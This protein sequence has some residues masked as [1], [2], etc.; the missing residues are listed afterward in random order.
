M[1][2][3]R[4]S[5]GF[6][7]GHLSG[8]LTGLTGLRTRLQFSQWFH[9][10]F[11]PALRPVLRL[12]PGFLGALLFAVMAVFARLCREEMTFGQLVFARASGAIVVLGV[13]FRRELKDVFTKGTGILW[14]RAFFG[15]V[16]VFCYYI[17]IYESSIGLATT[18]NNL[19]PVFVLLISAFSLK[20]KVSPFAVVGVALATVGVGV[21]SMPREGFLEIKVLATGI[22]GALAT[23]LAYLSLKKATGR[24]SSGV[25][26][27]CFSIVL[28]FF[29]L[30]D[31]TVYQVNWQTIPW[32][33]LM[34]M[35]LTALLA[36]LFMTISFRAQ[37]ATTGATVNLTVVVWAVLGDILI[38]GTHFPLSSALG[39]LAVLVGVFL[40]RSRES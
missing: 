9:H 23:A 38:L 4:F 16:A 17:N 40:C 35:V 37:T 6:T 32:L 12:W 3:K 34:G 39:V 2:R 30:L 33:A 7:A 25:V 14:M 8:F 22:T 20:K 5:G 26:V 1:L 24:F 15:S 18:L 11:P 28:L 29:S 21:L 19:A 27:L 10:W 36:Q 31:P 13:I